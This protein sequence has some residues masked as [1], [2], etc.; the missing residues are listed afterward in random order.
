MFANNIFPAIHLRIPVI[1]LGFLMLIAV[2]QVYNYA[3]R[4]LYLMLHSGQTF[5]TALLISAYLMKGTVPFLFIS[6]L[7][8]I[9]NFTI[10]LNKKQG[11]LMFS[12]R[13][14]RTA[15]LIIISMVIITGTDLNMLA[16]SLVFF[17]GEFLDRIMYYLDFDPINIKTTIKEELKHK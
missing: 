16:G 11:H 10:I 7:K 9:F 12:L 8:L 5:L 15:L 3:D 14:I 1:I 17:S 4:S 2:D 13:F 6:L